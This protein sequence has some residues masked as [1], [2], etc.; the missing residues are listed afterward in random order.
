MRPP[1]PPGLSSRT[2][3]RG[4]DLGGKRRRPR[5]GLCLWGTGVGRPVP[6][7]SCLPLDPSPG[8]R[9]CLTP[10]LSPRPR[11]CRSWGAGGEER[12]FL[13]GLTA[14]AGRPAGQAEPGARET[15]PAF[16]GGEQG[17]WKP[18]MD[19]P[20]SSPRLSLGAAPGGGAGPR[21]GGPDRTRQGVNQGHGFAFLLLGLQTLSLPQASICVSICPGHR[22]LRAG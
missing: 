6:R 8:A 11:G 4:T 2:L 22:W 7:E 15:P 9:G 1:G 3:E 12:G 20:C 17:T 19:F 10:R 14:C 13:G 21:M 5:C 18:S 16:P